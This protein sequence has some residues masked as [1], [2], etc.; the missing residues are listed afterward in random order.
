V[1][2]RAAGPVWQVRFAH[3]GLLPQ[4]ATM[5][6]VPAGR[7]PGRA[8]HRRTEVGH[9]GRYGPPRRQPGAARIAQILPAETAYQ[10]MRTA[11]ALDFAVT[12]MNPGCMAC[13]SPEIRISCGSSLEPPMRARSQIH[14]A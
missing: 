4:V 11:G 9:A 2:G 6:L 5:G 7:R 10:V 14:N 13:R 3:S 8:D 12:A 1:P